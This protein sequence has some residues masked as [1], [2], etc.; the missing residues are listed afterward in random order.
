MVRSW[1]YFI[2]VPFRLMEAICF[3][4]NYTTFLAKDCLIFQQDPFGRRL[5]PL[6]VHRLEVLE[7]EL[8]HHRLALEAEA[9]HLA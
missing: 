5:H 3:C 7:V 8:V 6:Q 9:Y 2:V 4:T 1:R